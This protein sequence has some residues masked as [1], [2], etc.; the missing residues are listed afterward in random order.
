MNITF[1]SDAILEF[2]GP[3]AL[4]H[5][6]GAEIYDRELI[7]RLRSRGHQVTCI[8]SPYVKPEQLEQTDTFF[9][10][11]NFV[12]LPTAAFPLLKDKNYIIV[13]HD[14]KYCAIRNVSDFEDF[15]VPA[16]FLINILFYENAL[17][18][19][20]QTKIHA[21]VISKN[22]PS[23]CNVINMGGSLWSE[24]DLSTIEQHTGA[25]KKWPYGVMMSNN[26]IKNTAR[27]LEYCEETG[28]EYYKIQ[29]SEFEKFVEDL[30]MCENFVFFPAVLETCCRAVVEARMLNCGIKTNGLIGA[31]SEEWFKL[32]GQ[33]LIDF[34]RENNNTIVDKIEVLLDQE[35][36]INHG[37]EITVILN[38]YRRPH[39]LEEQIAH[40]RQQSVRPRQIWVWVN[41]HIDNREFDFSA[42][43]A[44]RVFRNDHNWKFYGRFAAALLAD[45]EYIAMFDDD[46][47]PGTDWLLNCLQTMNVQEGIMGG[48]GVSLNS[49]LYADHVRHGWATHNEKTVEVDLV[50][51]AWLFKREWLSYLWRETPVTWDNGEDIQ[52]AYLAQ[53]YGKIR[54]Y[55][56]PHPKQFPNKSS[57]LRGYEL[58]VDDKAA[59]SP[60]NHHLFY[61]QRDAVI[62][63][64]LEGGWQLLKDQ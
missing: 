55:V 53:K 11:S 8:E 47:M 58:G 4:Q 51:H 29:K 64:A 23:T 5:L 21:E 15:K 31:T 24:Q 52:F 1:I 6:G 12:Q 39:L 14:H 45:T 17:A 56:P 3:E 48:I 59:S 49:K 36:I 60:E 18:V 20:A 30:S 33:E 2:H 27:A 50:G 62:A 40:I 63:N 32:K 61:S 42:V 34:V 35:N 7:E 43:G 46:T 38:A 41:D 57:S 26:P 54:S 25:E 10:I 19:C 37:R 28:E 44:D 16:K 22:L 13:E 9:I